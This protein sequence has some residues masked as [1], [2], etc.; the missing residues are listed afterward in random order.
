MSISEDIITKANPPNDGVVVV[1]QIEMTLDI[2]E[3][4]G[5]GSDYDFWNMVQAFS[6]SVD[7]MSAHMEVPKVNK[8]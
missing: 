7:I 1:L 5:M 4:R 8:T 2:E 3:L 6:P